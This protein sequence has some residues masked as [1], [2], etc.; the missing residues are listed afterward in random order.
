M[1]LLG[2]LLRNRRPD[3]RRYAWNQSNLSG[4]ET[5]EI[6]SEDFADGQ[7]LPLRHAGSRVGGANVSPQI[8]WSEPPEGT[9]EILLLIEDLD[10]PL[11]ANPAVHCLAVIDEDRLDKPRELASGALSRQNPAAGVT[12]LRST[13]GSGYHGPE[14][15][16][17]HGP[18]RYVVQLFAL[19]GSLPGDALKA[20]PRALLASV[21]APVLARGRITG[22]YER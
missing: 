11:G 20:R 21:E 22:T 9:A 7:P 15:V 4:P 16:K 2:T 6:T 5:L 14:P 10:V 3:E 18:H 17:G 12:L 8:G 19:G 13:I 1:S